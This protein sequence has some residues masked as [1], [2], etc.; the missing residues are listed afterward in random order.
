M[1]GVM[2]NS[3]G[4]ETYVVI[5]L[6]SLAE[7]SNRWRKKNNEKENNNQIIKKKKL[8]ADVYV[9]TRQHNW[10]LKFILANPLK[11]VWL[12]INNT[13]IVFSTVW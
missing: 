13:L 5:F 10:S 8:K 2:S 9:Y 4:K 6:R 1:K 12:N 11:S 7:C 3:R